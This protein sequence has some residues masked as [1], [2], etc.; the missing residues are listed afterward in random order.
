MAEEKSNPNRTWLYLGATFVAAWV[1]YLA[2]FVPRPRAVLEN[3]GISEPASYDWSLFDLDDRPVSFARFKG[4]RVFLNVWA[5]WC[6]PCVGEMPSIAQL[7]KEPRLAS[8]DIQFVCV[9]TDSSSDVVRRFLAGKNWS[10]TFLRAEELP[11]VFQTDG[12]PATFV[13]AAD[14]RIVASEIGAADWS[15]SRV[16]AFLEKL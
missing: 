16:V 4:K 1:V 5:T 9:S 7:A 6:G 8:K 12:I 11:T 10:M 15:E 2:F 3:S 14:G 13:I